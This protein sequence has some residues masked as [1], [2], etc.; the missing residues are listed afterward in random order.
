[1]PFSTISPY[2]I[3]TIVSASLIVLSQWAI[4]IVVIPVYSFLN[5][6]IAACTSAS[7]FLSRAEVASSSIKILGF[8][9]NALARAILCFSPPDNWPPPDPTQVL[10]PSGSLLTIYVAL[11][12]SK[13]SKI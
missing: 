11:A 10:I 4:M 13:A 2:F 9:I 7:F 1:M 5:L 6:S 12:F 8:L 3:T